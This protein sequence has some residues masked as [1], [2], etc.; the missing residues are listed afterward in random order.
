MSTPSQA[1]LMESFDKYLATVRGIMDE[2]WDKIVTLTAYVKTL[3]DEQ[4]ELRDELHA[5][6]SELHEAHRL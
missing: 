2:Q 6:I 1:A 3:Q 5:H 4:A